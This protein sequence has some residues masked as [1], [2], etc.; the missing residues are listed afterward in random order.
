MKRDRCIAI[1]LAVAV[2][3]LGGAAHASIS[4]PALRRSSPVPSEPSSSLAV[5]SDPHVADCGEVDVYVAVMPLGM[6][7]D[8]L[9][10]DLVMVVEPETHTREWYIVQSPLGLEEYT[11]RTPKQF[12]LVNGEPMVQVEYATKDWSYIWGDTE[13]STRLE[14]EKP[15]AFELKSEFVCEGDKWRYATQHERWVQGIQPVIRDVGGMHESAQTIQAIS[16]VATGGVIAYGTA[17]AWGPATK[18]VA[19]EAG[20]RTLPYLKQPFWW[21]VGQVSAGGR[22]AY[23][24]G[25]QAL[26]KARD[27]SLRAQVSLQNTLSSETG[28]LRVGS[29]SVEAARRVKPVNLPSWK[30]V[31]VHMQ[32]VLSGHTA[33]G[34]RVS[35]LKDL[36]PENMN[37]T[38]I[39]RAVRQA[40]RFGERVATQGDRV[41][42]RGSAAGMQIQM[43]VNTVTEAIETAYPIGKA[44]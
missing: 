40:Y 15:T 17:P 9:Y 25:S 16:L 43:W 13:I 37:A 38:Q 11:V 28:F 27:L 41:L 44:K 24:Y 20:R 39:E 23:E 36:F 33:G 2:V 29:R 30:K 8:G 14:W 1:L 35:S 32:H 12:M 26:D 5:S 22:A 21:I 31:A 7:D 10:L 19:K 34:S 3:A 4:T 6:T 18:E 42:V